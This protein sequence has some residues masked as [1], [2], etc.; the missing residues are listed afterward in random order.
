VADYR[1]IAADLRTGARIAELPLTG[2]SFSS[3][4]NG[5]GQLSGVLPLPSGDPQLAAV[6]NDAVDEVRRQLVVER[7]GTVVWCGVVWAS[8]Y[9]DVRQERSVM[10]AE[11][12]SYYRRRIIGTRRIYRNA[13]QFLIARQLLDD[14]HA[15]TGGSIG[16][17][18]GSETCGVNRDRN[19]EIWE[20]KN[21]GEAV[22]ELADVLNGFDFGI[23]A[24]WSPTG[25]LVKTFRLYYPRRGRRFEATGHV[26]EVGRNN[27]IS[28]DWPS[29][30]TRYANRII[31]I[32]AGEAES[33]LQ[34]VRTNTSQL[35][36]L[37]AGGPGYPLIEHVM[38]HVD[39]SVVSTLNAQAEKALGMFS[40]PV[41]V[42]T[43][44]VRADFN[45]IFGSYDLGDAVRFI[46]QPGGLSPRFPDGIDTFRR[47]VG[48]D[49]SV[50]DEGT[51]TV[52]LML[53]VEDNS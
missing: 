18:V 25:E 28:W 33:T 21:L 23:D 40:Q 49:V 7:D 1:V 22:E 5:A 30:G 39:V 38:S 46:V 27:L 24:A 47:I 9:D 14:A 34:S 35:V 52:K 41:V 10:A 31:N 13:D 48:W 32:G 29:D 43:I 16:V 12:W 2:L 51:D 36:A 44:E 6:Y 50:S 45:P 11:T 37:D 20:R 53:G 3:T 17:T 15:A 26:F 42:P 19:Y 4:L 8:P